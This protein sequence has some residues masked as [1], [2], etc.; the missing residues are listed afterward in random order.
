[1][2]AIRFG[3]CVEAEE[4]VVQVL[5]AIYT[6]A[7]SRGCP[8]HRD[9]PKGSQAAGKHDQVNLAF[10]LEDVGDAGVD[11]LT[12]LQRLQAGIRRGLPC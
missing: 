1:M 6:V 9:V 7:S 3:F 4:G 10:L 2:S 8:Q 5:E 12:D 11:I